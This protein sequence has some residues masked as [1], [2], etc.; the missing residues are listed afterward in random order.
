MHLKTNTT[1][2][3]LFFVLLLTSLYSQQLTAQDTI[4]NNDTL[5]TQK[6]EIKIV[7]VGDI[8][9]GT[10]YPLRSYLPPNEECSPLLEDVKSYLLEADLSFA[11][12]EGAIIDQG[13]M[14]KKCQDTLKCYAFR[15][16]EKFASC[17]SDVG[18]DILSLANNHSGDFGD[19]GRNKTMQL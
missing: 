11:N 4:T 1:I 6:K 19:E 8:M 14:A 15:M 12:L 7:G 5:Q 2:R 16:P 9:L 17:L 13:K 18:F 3:L 10:A